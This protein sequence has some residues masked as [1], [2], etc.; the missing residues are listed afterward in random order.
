MEYPDVVTDLDG[1]VESE[2][3]DRLD[4]S[5]KGGLTAAEGRPGEPCE[6]MQV[7]M[8]EEME[9]QE[10]ESTMSAEETNHGCFGRNETDIECTYFGCIF[11]RRR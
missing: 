4:E 8:P 3:L 11:A 10:L 6:C 2:E 9:S 5:T 7:V 1:F